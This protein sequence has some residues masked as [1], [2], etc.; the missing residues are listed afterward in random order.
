MRRDDAPPLP[1]P[2]REAPAAFGAPPAAGPLERARGPLELALR[3]GALLLLAWLL[4]RS[5]Q[6]AAPAGAERAGGAAAE[7]LVQWA[8]RPPGAAELRLDSLPHAAARD[9]A[10]ALRRSG[11]PVR[12]SGDSLPALAVAVAPVAD[13]AGGA[14]VSIAAGRGGRVA[15]GDAIGVVDSLGVAGAGATLSLASVAGLASAA[16]ERGTATAAAA[17]S[18]VLRRVLV[19]GRAGWEAKFAIAALEE[20]GWAVDAR[21]LVA[22]GMTVTQGSPSAPD[23]ARYAAVV[24]LDSTAAGEAARVARYVRGGGGLVLGADAARLP[25]FAAIAAAV[26]GPRTGGVLGALQ[27]DDPR[28][29]LALQPLRRL[30]PGALPLERR[31]SLVALAARR[32]GLGRVVQAG[33]EETWRWRM[34]GGPGAEDAHRAWWAR[35]IAAAAYAPVVARDGGASGRADPAPRASLAAALGAPV[36]AV[37]DAAPPSREAMGVAT[38]TVLALLLLLEW[39]SRRLRGAR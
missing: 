3:A 19:V 29:G 1:V 15:I 2:P 6:P 32:V 38:F 27:G 9:L 14:Q 23:T 25:G 5:L 37:V 26:P 36:D 30:A 31:D 34:G 11:I 18:V 20:R 39:G 28:R 17:D 8:A 10:V 21:L 35:V 22:P 7:R 4:W 12:W 13:P 16:T 24:A 33:Y